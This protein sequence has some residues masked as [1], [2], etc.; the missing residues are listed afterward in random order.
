MEKNQAGITNECSLL[1]RSPFS[2]GKEVSLEMPV[3][4]P[5]VPS[6]GTER[7]FPFAPGHPLPVNEERD[8]QQRGRQRVR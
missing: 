5:T 6:A 7:Q 8:S 4:G 1:I 3:L 2:P